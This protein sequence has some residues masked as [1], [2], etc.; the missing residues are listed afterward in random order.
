MF[1]GLSAVCLSSAAKKAVRLLLL[2][3]RPSSLRACFWLPAI[4]TTA[5]KLNPSPVKSIRS[6]AAL[7]LGFLR[8]GALLSLVVV[9]FSLSCEFRWLF[10]S[11]FMVFWYQTPVFSVFY[12][13]VYEGIC[14]CTAVAAAVAVTA[15]A[16]SLRSLSGWILAVASD[17]LMTKHACWRV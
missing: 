10:T 12:K 9:E 4:P 8:P 16:A 2:T 15:C 7:L 5:G 6:C 14:C 3:P 17:A 11:S 13:G 1:R